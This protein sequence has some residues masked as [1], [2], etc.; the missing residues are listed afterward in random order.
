MFDWKKD[1]DVLCGKK[2]FEFR[3]RTNPNPT[4]DTIAN[5]CMKNLNL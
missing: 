4:I 5:E 1:Y 2:N 3:L